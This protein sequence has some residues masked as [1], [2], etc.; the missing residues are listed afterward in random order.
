MVRVAKRPAAALANE[1][2]E[3]ETRVKK[4][5]A[6]WYDG[7]YEESDNEWHDDEVPDNNDDDANDG[8]GETELA[9]NGDGEDQAGTSAG[10]DQ[11]GTSADNEKKDET[12]LA[13][14]QADTRPTTRAQRYVF[15]RDI[16]ALPEEIKTV[17]GEVKQGSSIGKQAKVNAI[18]NACVPRDAAYKT[19]ARVDKMQYQWM[20]RFVDTQSIKHKEHGISR[21][22]MLGRLNGSST[23][24]QEG[25]DCGDV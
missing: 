17:Y 22:E 1:V 9:G 24:L 6:Q 14:T 12:A 25:L 3:V 20:L 4:K 11:T 23:L 5:P 21:T 10:D 8:N 19:K 7:D 16:D 13:A 2:K 15:A 18:V